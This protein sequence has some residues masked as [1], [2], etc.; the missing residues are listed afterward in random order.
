MGRPRG[1][2]P[3]SPPADCSPPRRELEAGPPHMKEWREGGK[4][5]S[6]GGKGA[7]VRGREGRSEGARE[8]GKKDE[9]C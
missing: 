6:E 3:A 4:G 5:R 2:Q 9:D 8:V 7:R 1:L